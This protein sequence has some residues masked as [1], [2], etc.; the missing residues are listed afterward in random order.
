MMLLRPRNR[1]IALVNSGEGGL[2]IFYR[3]ATQGSRPQI[4]F[5]ATGLDIHNTS[6]VRACNVFRK[7][8]R[9]KKEDYSRHR[10]SIYS[11]AF[12]PNSPV[13]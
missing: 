13:L 8:E 6:C 9:R 1:F 2:L 3:C 11:V 5:V 7:K 10:V 4:D 12:P